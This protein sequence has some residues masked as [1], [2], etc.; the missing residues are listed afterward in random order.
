[1]RR[2][3]SLFVARDQGEVE[4]SHPVGRRGFGDRVGLDRPHISDQTTFQIVVAAVA[5]LAVTQQVSADPAGVNDPL[6]YLITLTNHGPDRATGVILTDALPDNATFL[7]A[8]AS[9]GTCTEA[10]GVVTCNLDDVAVGK[11]AMVKV[12]VR[13]TA[14][15]RL[16]NRVDAR[17]NEYDPTPVRFLADYTDVMMKWYLPVWMWEGGER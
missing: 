1:M 10:S 7:S 3:F 6:T 17:S 12:R 11:Q 8:Q 5:D 2:G 13:P 9:Q 16:L 4:G 15:G 14:V